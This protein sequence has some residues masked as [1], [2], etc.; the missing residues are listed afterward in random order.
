MSCFWAYTQEVIYPVIYAKSGDYSIYAYRDGNRVIW[1][2]HTDWPNKLECQWYSCS[3]IKYRFAAIIWFTPSHLNVTHKNIIKK[4][5]KN[6]RSCEV[7]NKVVPTQRSHVLFVFALL[8]VERRCCRFHLTIFLCH[9][10]KRN[11]PWQKISYPFVV[12]P[13]L[14]LSL[15]PSYSLS[16]FL[17]V[18]L[19]HLSQSSSLTLPPSFAISFPLIL[20]SLCLFSLL[21]FICSLSISFSLYLTS[22]FIHP[23]PSLIPLTVII[24]FCF[25]HAYC[26]CRSSFYKELLKSIL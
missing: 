2:G 10:E 20:Y 21:C 8:R 3:I 6:F 9:M 23:S 16:R 18:L 7:C 12:S 5:V 14:V 24:T 13:C 15:S 17:N 22:S 4:C 19:S 26:L 1:H 25:S 11:C